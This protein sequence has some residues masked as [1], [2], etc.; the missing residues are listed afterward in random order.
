[1]MQISGPPARTCQPADSTSRCHALKI[2][3][4][5]ISSVNCCEDPSMPSGSESPSCTRTSPQLSGRQLFNVG[6]MAEGRQLMIQFINLQLLP[7]WA[8]PQEAVPLDEAWKAPQ[9]PGCAQQAVRKAI[10]EAEGKKLYLSSSPGNVDQA[11][12]C[13]QASLHAASTLEA[14]PASTS[15]VD[16]VY[17]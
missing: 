6:S 10:R 5:V 9:R 4:G 15:A 3:G 2:A 12:H 16:P 1:M 13:A 7:A 14:D 8:L 17:E 11:W